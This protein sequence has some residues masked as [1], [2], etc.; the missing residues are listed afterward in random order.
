MKVRLSCP[1]IGGSIRQRGAAASAGHGL[2]V[3]LSPR[4]AG[5]PTCSGTARVPKSSSCLST[6][7]SLH[8]IRGP[9]RATSAV[10][11]AAALA[12]YRVGPR[13][14]PSAAGAP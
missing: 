5:G 1:A 2:S 12:P 11:A 13:R 7:S 8:F 6:F 3:S 14:P 4:R 10:V 9:L